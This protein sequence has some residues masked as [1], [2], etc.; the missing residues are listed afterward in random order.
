MPARFSS[1]LPSWIA[2]TLAAGL[3]ISIAAPRGFA[4]P[5]ATTKAAPR[6][7]SVPKHGALAAAVPFI[8]D[9][10][11]R[12]LSLAKQRKAPVF[13]EAWA[14][15]CHTCRSMRAYV[16][17]D[18][19]LARHAERFVWLS[20]DAENSVNAEVRK[21]YPLPALPSYYVIDPNT[22]KVTMRMVGSMTV[23]QLHHFLD[24]AIVSW[25]QHGEASPADRA[26]ARADSLYGE[27]QDSLA[28]E[29]YRGAIALAPAN[30][31][32][33]SRAID[34]LLFALSNTNQNQAVVDVAGVA[35]TRLEGQSTSANV[36]AYGLSSAVALPDSNPEKQRSVA[37]FERAVRSI[38]ADSKLDLAG[39]DRS[40]VYISLLDALQ[41]RGDSTAAHQVAIEWSAFL[42]GAAA[43]AKTP[44]AR[45]VFDSH[46]L[47][48][49]LELGTPEKAVPMLEASERD[50]PQD[51]NPPARLATAL[52][53]MKRY[54]TALAASDRAM[55]LA[56][57]PR[58]FLLWRTRI[59]I[60][61]DRGDPADTRSALAQAI[62]EAESMP[63]SQRSTRTID[64][65]KKQL[66]ELK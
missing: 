19:T 42:D 15:W 43:K 36:A 30:W 26:L 47:S 4:A 49:Y 51:Y 7:T 64:G 61:T 54:D 56:Y 63:E 6:P 27:G 1:P 22:E 39:D 34:A 31:P 52:R 58:R 9:D 60:L 29:A 44:D 12:A 48:A 37:H 35:W 5:L 14:P 41:E 3:A 21:R 2:L 62:S 66:A 40:G 17:T 53:A 50:L 38:L 18:P 65:F 20:V 25:T 28:A 45:A 11:A 13:V 23:T 33:Y 10:L 16:F 8:D 59:G 57:G 24:Q 32:S 55:A 46:R